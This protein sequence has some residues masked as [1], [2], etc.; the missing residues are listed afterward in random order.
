MY[1]SLIKC[2][3]LETDIFTNHLSS[4]K[5]KKKK[6]TKCF[7]DMIFVLGMFYVILRSVFPASPPPPPPTSPP[8]PNVINK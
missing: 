5:K 2:L 3:S 4:R 7:C 1:Y 6:W 8:T